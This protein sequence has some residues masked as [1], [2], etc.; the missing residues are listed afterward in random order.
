MQN[1]LCFLLQA[2]RNKA[3]KGDTVSG[4]RSRR[5]ESCFARLFKGPILFFLLLFLSV[6][7][8]LLTSINAHAACVTLTWDAGPDSNAAGYKLYYGTVN[9][10][11]AYSIDVGNT[12]SYALS[13]LSTD[14]TYYFV[15]AGYDRA[16]FQSA[17]SNE[18]SYTVPSA[19]TYSTSPTNPAFVAAGGMGSVRVTTQTGCE[20]AAVSAAS[21][22]SITS[23]GTGTGSGTVGYT[24]ATNNAVSSRTA[25]STIAGHLFTLRQA[26]VLPTP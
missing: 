21:W 8:L 12:T 6:P 13:S 20:W 4:S 18:V 14:A 23:G 2:Q 16:G 24:V 26:G 7:T 10:S 22:M 25:A 9:G 17:Y 3:T 1:F 15:L 5:I 19:C 11:Y